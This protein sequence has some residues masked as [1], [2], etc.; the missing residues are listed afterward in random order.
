MKAKELPPLEWLRE[1]LDYN[2]VTGDITIK[3]RWHKRHTV[4]VG[5]TIG[6]L[7]NGYL[8]TEVNK[9]SFFIHRVAYAIYHG[10]LPVD[11]DIIDHI[12]GNPFDN[13]IENLREC[14]NSQNQQ[15]SRRPKSNT[16]GVKGV[17]WCKQ[18]QKWRGRITVDGADVHIGFFA[19]VVEAEDAMTAARA[20]LHGLFARSV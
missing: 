20:K 7:S 13:R 16:S 8:R 17:A 14:N 11:G 19:T 10:I 2:P 12:N 3:K 9:K 18:K 6:Y 5:K 4:I 15:N 1:H